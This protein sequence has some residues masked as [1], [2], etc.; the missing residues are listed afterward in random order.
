MM[1]RTVP[2]FSE[3]NAYYNPEATNQ[4]W[5]PAIASKTKQISGSYNTIQEDLNQPGVMSVFD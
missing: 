1:E 2:D 5:K 3:N 4:K